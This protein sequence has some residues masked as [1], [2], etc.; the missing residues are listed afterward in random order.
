MLIRASPPAR[1]V[2]GALDHR[3]FLVI[4]CQDEVPS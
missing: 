1:V 4:V 2:S 3:V